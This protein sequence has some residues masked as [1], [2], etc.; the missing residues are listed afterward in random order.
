MSNNIEIVEEIVNEANSIDHYVGN[1]YGQFMAGSLAWSAAGGY[2]N[3]LQQLERLDAVMADE[4][5]IGGVSD[6]TLQH[7]K[8]TELRKAEAPDRYA[9]WVE[10]SGGLA[11][12]TATPEA[13]VKAFSTP[14]TVQKS[15]LPDT[16][17][18]GAA[19]LE[20]ITGVGVEMWLKAAEIA[21]G[22]KAQRQEERN[23]Q[24]AEWVKSHAQELRENL[25]RAAS[26]RNTGYLEISDALLL[27]SL[28]K[29]S[30]KCDTYMLN[31][32]VAS[33]DTDLNGKQRRIS[34]TAVPL[35]K[36]L[37]D[38]IEKHIERIR[39]IVEGAAR[40]VEEG[41]CH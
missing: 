9:L 30:E 10:R 36:A 38:K 29:L 23:K 41:Q 26:G 15:G 32:G 19:M 40:D 13:V 21:A 11:N 27:A 35:L 2:N 17:E 39:P 24:A 25:T 5:E 14:R 3:A 16:A 37:R 7:V 20:T 8:D 31:A 34:L 6:E 28:E 18:E 22:K 4:A 33:F 12:T 1:D